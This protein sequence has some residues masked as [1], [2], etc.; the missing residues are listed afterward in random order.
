MEEDEP[1]REDRNRESAQSTGDREIGRKR[2]ETRRNGREREKSGREIENGR[3][4]ERK[5]GVGER[6]ESRQARD[7]ARET[8]RCDAH[9]GFGAAPASRRRFL[10]KVASRFSLAATNGCSVLPEGINT[11]RGEEKHRERETKRERERECVCVFFLCSYLFRSPPPPGCPLHSALRQPPAAPLQAALM[12]S[13]VRHLLVQRERERERDRCVCV[14]VCVRRQSLRNEPR[15]KKEQTNT[16]LRE[17][18]RE[19]ERLICI[20]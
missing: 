15:P 14:C 7:I 12:G 4:R 5:R 18:E 20:P 13:L 10:S 9:F 2:A 1:G 8:A 11:R 6:R 3:D 16:L 19:R 17:R